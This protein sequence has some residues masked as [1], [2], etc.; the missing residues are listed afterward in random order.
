MKFYGREAELDELATIRRLSLESSRF[1][2]VTGR[3]RVGKTELV[4]KALRDGKMPYLYLLISQ[5]AEKDL[6]A[7][8]QENISRVLTR[9]L[10]GQ[11]ERFG[12]LFRAVLEYS[13]ETPLTLVIDE[14]Q[15]TGY[16]VDA[17]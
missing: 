7:V 2:V 14:F 5:R 12:Q 16:A 11:A 15:E 6:C 9:P 1:T 8:L 17:T 13:V 3:R 4:E 10:L